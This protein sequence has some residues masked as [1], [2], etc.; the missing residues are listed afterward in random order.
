MKHLFLARLARPR[1]SL[2]CVILYSLLL[3]MTMPAAPL[4]AAVRQPV[5]MS[6]DAVAAPAADSSAPSIVL[7][8]VIRDATAVAGVAE[9][10]PSNTLLAAIDGASQTT[11]ELID[12]TG[13][14]RRLS[15]LT[16]MDDAVIASTAAG[17]VFI[18][19]GS[20]IARVAPDGTLTSSFASVTG[21]I[22]ALHTSATHHLIA[23]T[24]GGGVWRVSTTG[25][26]THVADCGKA[27]SAVITVPDDEGRY[28]AWAGAILVAAR[29]EARLFAIDAAGVVEPF[30]IG[31]VARDLAL[32][33]PNRN[34]FG[35]D[36]A[37]A[38]IRGARAEAFA[39]MEGDIVVAQHAPGILARV[40]WNGTTFE[41]IQIGKAERWDRITFA[42]AGV[43]AIPPAR[44]IYDAIAVV[45]HAPMLDS[46]RIEGALWQ[47]TA[48]NVTLDGTDVITSDLLMPGT[49]SVVLGSGK[50][51][52]AGVITGSDGSEPKTHTLSISGSAS[53]RH[54][55]N[56]TDPIELTSIVPPPAPTGTRD[57]ALT[58]AGSVG[59][60][61]T[62]RDLSI[63]GKAGEVVIPPGTYGRFEATGRT[64]FILGSSGTRSTYNLTRLDLAGG[65]ELRVLG[66][67]VV[68]LRDGVTVTGSSAGTAEAPARLVLNVA[69]GDVS[70][71]GT[72]VVNALVRAPGSR[73]TIDGNGLLRGSI[74]ADRLSVTGNGVLQVTQTDVP[75][76]ATNR[77]P[78]VDAGADQ[79]LTL[80]ADTLRLEGSVS[81]DALPRNAQ[82]TI[83][84][85]R[86]SGPDAVAFSD[87][88]TAATSARFTVPGT[89]VLRLTVDDGA[90]RTSDDVTITVIPEN[91]PPAAEAG[92][93]QRIELPAKA[94]LSGTATD[95][96]LPAGSSLVTT[97][98]RVAGPGTV[99]FDDAT[100]LATRAAFTAAG[101]H[102][103][104]L[105]ATDGEDTVSDDLTIT[106]DSEN[107]APLVAAGDDQ[108]IVLPNGTTLRGTASDDGWPYGSTFTTNWTTLS[109][110][111]KVT[112]GDTTN[113]ETTATFTAAGV[114][115]LRLSATD[116]R[117]T[118][119]DDVT[120]TVDPIN[121][122]PLV[123]A[124]ADSVVELPEPAALRGSVT[125]DG[126]P[127]GSTLTQQ[128]SVV[129]GT[130]VTFADATA[131]STTATFVSA[132]TYTLRLTAT[133]GALS[134]SD[135]VTLTVHPENQPPAVDAG[136][137][138]TIRLPATAALSGEASDDGWPFGS[139][140]TTAWSKASGPGSVTFADAAALA[141][142][143]SF[144]T[145]GTYVLRLSATD[146]RVT[147]IDELTVVVLPAN[148]P[149]VVHAGAD[150]AASTGANLVRNGGGEAVR[151]DG[152]I[153]GWSVT[154]GN[155]TR[156]E[157][158]AAEGDAYLVATAAGELTQ[159]IA[160]AGLPEG[161]NFELS[162]SLRGAAR[163]AF[164]FRGGDGSILG[165]FEAN[166]AS[167]A[168][169]TSVSETRAGP[170]GTATVAVRLM[171]TGE[172][173]FDAI[174]VRAPG[175]ATIDLLGTITDDGLP[176][177]STLAVS[178]SAVSGPAAIVFGDP[179]RAKT[180]AAFSQPGTYVLRLDA[181]DGEMSAGDEM[182]VVVG[183]ANQPPA[184]DA[185]AAQSVRL[186]ATV[187]LAGRA[188]DDGLP[189]GSALSISWTALTGA[190]SVSIAGPGTLTPTLTFAT[191]G[192]FILRLTVTDSEFTI[193]DDVTITVAAANQPPVVSA[194]ADVTITLP[195]PATLAG[196]AS[197]EDGTPVA[198]Q[199]TV[200]SGGQVT[201]ADP[202]SATTTA[203]F[204]AAGTYI[205]R[206]TGN[207][208]ELSASDDV[209]ITVEAER[210]NQAPVVDAGADLAIDLG[211]AVGLRGSATDDG[212]PRASVLT[213]TWAKISGPGSVVFTDAAAAVTEASFDAP[214]I[215]VLRL[216][217]SDSALSS[218]DDVSVT[219]TPAL[220]ARFSVAGTARN[221]APLRSNIAS[222]HSGA[223]VVAA[224]ASSPASAVPE[225]ALDDDPGSYWRVS[226]G[227]TAPFLIVRLP[228]ATPA[229]FDRIR[230]VT[231]G[232]SE[233][234]LNFRVQV[235]STT[236]DD[237]AFTTILT[238]TATA[239][240]RVQE[241][242]LATPAQG[243]YVRLV[244]LS[245]RTGFAQVRSFDAVQAEG[246]GVP[247]Y[248]T[249]PSISKA[250]D[251]AST[252]DATTG[253][254]QAVIDG[255][256]NT[257]WATPRT[258]AQS[259]TI[260]LPQTYLADRIRIVNSR[261]AVAMKNF[262]VEV[263]SG[264][265][266]TFTEV[267][268]GVARNDTDAPQEFVFSSPRQTRL[269]RFT[270]LDNY[271]S[272]T[273]MSVREIDVV[274]VQ[275]HHISSSSYSE[276]GVGPERVLDDTPTT[277][278]TSAA[279]R[280]AGEFIVVRVNPS[281][282]APVA[283]VTLQST[284]AH[285]DTSAVREFDVFVSTTT[286]D[287]AA[288]TKVL[289]GTAPQLPQAQFFRFSGGPIHARF[290]KLVVRSNYGGDSVRVAT[291]WPMTVE[292][293][294]SAVSMTTPVAPTRNL[295]PA[296]T[297][298]GGKIVAASSGSAAGMLDYFHGS[299]WYTAGTTNQWV[300]IE[301]AGS[302]THTLTGVTIAPELAYT[303]IPNAFVRD[304]EIWVSAT[305]AEESAFSKVFAGAATLNDVNRFSF[306]PVMARYVKYVPL[307]AQSATATSI[308]TGYFDVVIE[309]HPGGVAGYSSRFTANVGELAFDGSTGTSWYTATGAVTDQWITVA[310]PAGEVRPVH[311][312]RIVAPSSVAP[313]QFEIRVST[314]TTDPAAFT[315]VLSGTYHT[316]F[317]HYYFSAPHAAKY[318][319]FFW[320]NG[321][322]TSNIAV[323]ELGVLTVPSDGAA[324]IGY[325][326]A[327]NA[328]WT[329]AGT[330][331]I[332]PLNNGWTTP[333]GR[334]ANEHFTVALRGERTWV[335]DHVSMQGALLNHSSYSP[336]DFEVQVSDG[337]GSNE[338]FRTVLM[339]TLRREVA[340]QEQHFFFEP[341]RARYVRV[342][343]RNNWGAP[344]IIMQAF[345]VYSSE[346]GATRAQF[347]DTSTGAP[348][349]WQW[350]FGDGAT[351]SERSPLHVYA[352]PGVY[353]VHLTVTDASSRTSTHTS[354]Y[355][356]T[357]GPR[358]DFTIAPNPGNEGSG[359]NVVD[360][361]T[362]NVGQLQAHHWIWGDGKPDD[363]VNASSSHTYTDN[364]VY[365]ITH[366][367]RNAYGISAT[368]QKDVTI[369]NVP[370]TA[371][372]GPDL[373]VQ[374]G[375]DWGVR[376]F[377][378]DAGEADR[379]SLRCVWTFGDGE[380]HEQ[381][382]CYQ[383][384]APHAY[385]DPGVYAATLTVF[386][387]DGAS[388]T[389]SVKV[390]VGLRDT[391]AF[392]SGQREVAPNE[393]MN[394]EAKLRDAGRFTPIVG[395]TLQFDVGGQIV[396]ATTDAQGI[397]TAP[398]VYTGPS[399][400]P[401]VTV[402][403][404][405][406][407]RYLA[408]SYAFFANCAG[409]PRPLDIALVFDVSGSLSKP[410]PFAQ[411]AARDF[412]KS[413]APAHQV[414]VVSFAD[415]GRLDQPLTTDRALAYTAIDNLAIRGGTQIYHGIR[416][417]HDELVGLRHKPDAAPVM[418]LLSDGEDFAGQNT[419]DAANRAKAAGIRIV[420]V[421]F[422]E[423]STGK[424]LMKS[425]ASSVADYWIAESSEA[426]EGI[427]A[428]IVDTLCTPANRPPVVV[429]G[430]DQTLVLPQNSVALD[431]T[432]TDDG[433]PEGQTVTTA[434][435]KSSGPGTVAFADANAVDTT[436]TFSA[437]GVYVLTLTANDTEFTRVDQV[438]ITVAENDAPV[439]NAGDDR[440][441][442]LPPGTVGLDGTVTDDGL[443]TAALS[444]AWTVSSGPGSV[445]FADPHA[446][447]TTA[448][449]TTPGTYVL[450]LTA[451][452]SLLESTDQIVLTVAENAPPTV[453]A[454]IDRSAT[455]EANLLVNGGNDES[456]VDGAIRGW[457]AVSGTWL[458]PQPGMNGLPDAVRGESYFFAGGDATAEL[459]QD[460]DVSAFAARI[461]AGQQEFAW[462]AFART[463]AEA[464]P[465][466]ADVIVE[467]R[468]ASRTAVLLGRGVEITGAEWTKASEI[469]QAPAGTRWI[470]VRVKS[471]RRSG[472]ATDVFVD[473]VT[474][475]AIG[476]AHAALAGNASDDGIPEPLQAAWTVVS[477]PGSVTFSDASSPDASAVADAAGEYMLR[478]TATDGVTSVSDDV[479]LTVARANAAP[480]VAAG[481]DAEIRL[482]SSATLS[483]TSS[484]DGHPAP[485]SIRWQLLSGPEPV[486]FSDANAA[487]THVT[488]ATGGT[489]RFRV[490]ADD[491]DEIAFDTVTINVLSEAGNAAPVVDAGADVLISPPNTSATLAAT[492]TDDG[493]PSGS[494]LGLTWSQFSGPGTTTFSD[495][496]SRAPTVTFDR[497]GIYVLRLTATD[498]ELTAT[499]DM[500][501]SYDGTNT[502][503][504]VDAG[505]DQTVRLNVGA[506]L[507]ATVADD[508]LPLGSTLSLAWSKVSGPGTVSFASNTSA[509]TNATFSETGS[510]VLRLTASD[511]ALSATDEMTITVEPALPPPTVDITSPVSGATITD[512]TVFSGVVSEGATWR[513]E[514][515]LNG[516]DA[517]AGKNA[518]T[519]LA[520]GVGP[521]NGPL[522]TFD[523]TVLLNGT[524][525]VRLVAVGDDGQTETVS[526]TA[527][528][529]GDLKLGLFTLSFTDLKVPVGP[530]PIELVRT[531]DSRDKRVGDFGTGWTLEL[532]SI[533]LDKSGVLGT[534]WE[535]TTSGFFATKTYCLVAAVPRYVTVTFPNGKVFRFRATPS[536]ECQGLVPIDTTTIR[537]VPV[538]HTR[539]TLVALGDNDVIVSGSKPGPVELLNPEL[540]NPS[541]FRLTLNDGTSYVIDEVL[542]V[543]SVTDVN[544]N[545]ITVGE[546]GV[547]HS[548]G[549][550]VAFTRDAAG[551]ITRITDPAGRTISY[552]YDGA[553]D[554]VQVTNRA[555]EETTYTYAANHYL[556]SIKDT[557]GI[558]P[559]RNEFDAAGRLIRTTDAQGKVTVFSIDVA[560][561]TEVITDRAGASTTLRYDARGNVLASTD[562]LGNR[563]TFTYD[564]AGNKISMTNAVGKTVTYAYDTR[565]NLIATTDPLGNMNRYEHDD[566][567]RV[568][569]HVDANGGVTTHK[570]DERGRPI[571]TTDTLG[572]VTK[573]SYTT[574]G[575]VESITHPNGSVT[576]FQHN[577]LG[578][579][580]QETGPDGR[581]T[582]FEFDANG[583][584]TTIIDVPA[585]TAAASSPVRTNTDTASSGV[586]VGK[587]IYDEEDRLRRVDYA[588][589]G[590]RETEYDHRRLP[591]RETDPIGRSVTFEYDSMGRRIRTNYPDGSSDSKTY[592]AEGRVIAATD[593]GGLTTQYTW[594]AVG[595]LVQATLPDGS[596]ISA[597]YDGL[598][599]V[600]SR[601]L[602]T[603]ART[604]YEYDPNCG[605]TERLT[606]VT[607]ALGQSA[608][609]TYDS[610]NRRTS[611]TDAQGRTTTFEY[612]AGN[613]VS[614]ITYADGTAK[615]AHYNATGRLTMQTD[616]EGKVT[617]FEYDAADRPTRVID[618]LGQVTQYIYDSRG[619]LAESIDAAGRKS[620]F[621]YDI[622]DRRTGRTLPL[623]MTQT[624]TYD[625]AGQIL[626]RTDFNGKTTHY[627]Y[628]AMGRTLSETPDA[629]LSDSAVT[630]QY[631]AMG[632]RV[633]MQDPSGTT[634]YTYDE[635]HRLVSVA[636]PAG[637]LT[638]TYNSLNK[639]T[640]VRSS[641]TDG[642]AV[643]YAYDIIGRLE[644][645]TDHRTGTAMATYDY[646]GAGNVA[647]LAYGN[648]LRTEYA[649]DVL[650]RL[651][652]VKTWA[653]APVAA[654]EYTL[655][656]TGR[657]VGVTELGG[658]SVTYSYDALYR[659]IRERVTGDPLGADGQVDYT[660]DAVGNRLTRTSTLMGVADAAYAYD[661]ND[662]PVADTFD[663][664][665]NP[666]AA[667]GTEF[668]YDFA[669]RLTNVGDSITIV[670]NGDGDRASKTVGG[671]T[672]HY[673]VDRNNP[674]GLAQV[675]E[676]IQAGVVQRVYT[677]GHQLIHQRQ[678]AGG[679]WMSRYY[680]H[681]GHGSTRY[682]ADD[683]G[684]VTDTYTYDAFGVLIARTGSTPNN[685]L[686]AGEQFDPDLGMYYLRARY[687]EPGS[688]R[689]WTMDAYEGN[690][691]DP[692]SL[693]K[694]TYVH[695]D[696]VNNV[697]P[698]GFALMGEMVA[699]MRTSSIL[700]TIGTFAMR[701]VV[702]WFRRALIGAIAGAG[703][704]ATDSA[705]GALEEGRIL[706]EAWEGGKKGLVIGAITGPLVAIRYIKEALA[707]AGVVVSVMGA[708]DSARH[709]KYAQATFRAMTALIP[710]PY[711][712][713]KIRQLV[714][715]VRISQGGPGGAAVTGE[716]QWGARTYSTDVNAHQSL[717]IQQ[718]G[719]DG[720]KW[721]ESLSPA[722][723]SHSGNALAA[724][725][726]IAGGGTLWRGGK[727]DRSN[728]GK[729]AQYWAAEYPLNPDYGARYGLPPENT[730]FDFTEMA[731]IGNG[732]FITRVSPP[733]GTNP[734]GGIEIVVPPGGTTTTGFSGW[735]N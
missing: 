711:V 306:A 100:Q 721:Y 490:S 477:G 682:L 692:P 155:F 372:A 121:E 529:E 609:F 410:L 67:V 34:F 423:S 45:R 625:K 601:T 187:T 14:R 381:A 133:D 713:Q 733:V 446:V 173:S 92:A 163:V 213:M 149:P 523:P 271:G 605:C 645:V 185:G 725:G 572:N 586:P 270:M 735:G 320:Q 177:G 371:N 466:A 295:S 60:F 57:V 131:A 279:Q 377:T 347:V 378:H 453:S 686:Y 144:A 193:H 401:K 123:S 457:T 633:A 129:A 526:V 611:A 164:E 126:W 505:V 370:P 489:Y 567:G 153:E 574:A 389:D 668:S 50:P 179:S 203:G 156:A 354:K 291:F 498:G 223:S 456:L 447:D 148:Q 208:G 399:D 77:P 382:D 577:Q 405:G 260:V 290:V 232:S 485:L 30:S 114:Y 339:G 598:G 521:V 243:R 346:A 542:G 274:P 297:A 475:R 280:T 31:V 435:S 589:G 22:A 17:D 584:Q 483:A 434:W 188:S 635:L 160:V 135:E 228:G 428:S 583:N 368:A 159:N 335:V 134:V 479:A 289:S 111:G 417:A 195:D 32:V 340:A 287:P 623:G 194:G 718:K 234:V 308:M 672:T 56:R 54:L 316:N 209:T 20:I 443:P 541:Q 154:S 309:P 678:L 552:R 230:L 636:S 504:T 113:P 499:D 85:T 115:V 29:D 337:D 449:F 667:R 436:A 106:V 669:D 519:V 13:S 103:L 301:L 373:T 518:W 704:G 256:T 553:G 568:L 706:D 665:G 48:E 356:A 535:E 251:R 343:V 137:D 136:A 650:D 394:L 21:E 96:G 331:D 221:A 42:A 324:L 334:T 6:D 415:E 614:R 161:S 493:L 684:V 286:D 35:V 444:T 691:F 566:A 247:N 397:A 484:D 440:G 168:G 174:S 26:A 439:V 464:I 689:F 459:Q 685:Y 690:G 182:S 293:E 639:V 196:S 39:A 679:T 654:Y 465:D 267:L 321:T 406:D 696:P 392:Y 204:A 365:T 175:L 695:G 24:S 165:S 353:D 728:T 322:S 341:V 375:D 66:D 540:Y 700:S 65:S 146:T 709:G 84:W 413:L 511:T 231:P 258:P 303:T 455:I 88:S 478:L 214:G 545:T 653:A 273:T 524:Y 421:V 72:A 592:D 104:R 442:A 141:T 590:F 10:V 496:T 701:G 431:A 349:A 729:D 606:K 652:S 651:Q 565:N 257:A 726:P 597:T 638:Y 226:V 27:A 666:L 699:V 184:V 51:S 162:A 127:R 263:T 41:T 186:P 561:R 143:A 8:E 142:T 501:V 124:D 557:K 618:A 197:D 118:R 330:L 515:R 628:D 219:V 694:Y 201:F 500:T 255:F 360:R 604:T 671:V 73:V 403:F 411:S 120:I 513:L 418:I 336:R 245:A 262:R 547:V 491:S 543:R 407:A 582:Q 158:G 74:G 374:W 621:A 673:L 388:A 710:I 451:S 252:S 109:G 363:R 588:D 580:T 63:S 329:P 681:D 229:T 385:A 390:T 345:R 152:T 424:L 87:A 210:V 319:Q 225:Q 58:S 59:D 687:M 414:A 36:R 217:A 626:S 404:A 525:K 358:V 147:T 697:D 90:L 366:T 722:F 64:A 516:N 71:S 46:G 680:G 227:T 23:V 720:M 509:I 240:D 430:T 259:L 546:T 715:T 482:P 502:A 698:T 427:Y 613:R 563:T 292:N 463:A 717:A 278:W 530:L 283:G 660:H 627:S 528:V 544:G 730:N 624:V 402:S 536:V 52:F 657:R 727:L 445:T 532:K 191:A 101:V 615:S 395:A 317:T 426:L 116:G 132:G 172:A 409:N 310:L 408:S 332:E 637:T 9:H 487:S 556:T 139:T 512:R 670:Y 304:F 548:S 276:A 81:D 325:S 649:Y 644:Q 608:A 205:L 386:D 432:V 181:T 150:A 503:P 575:A 170:A 538:G 294:G 703:L 558:Q 241:F 634:R 151:A 510:Y 461:D 307:S 470:R 602:P 249:P 55:V 564:G 560:G 616:Q 199:W 215:Y 11:L 495:A 43:G 69:S 157:G 130:G 579:V 732:P 433:L 412:V 595:R 593:R 338:S 102:T 619:N 514:Y 458:R 235:S 642:L 4:F 224:T 550:S 494:T 145:A 610:L 125:D 61:A 369:L 517:A 350:Q 272:S 313:K 480:S 719:W 450:T 216:T 539:G 622:M 183:T 83:E 246:S 28:G 167:S 47:L 265:A 702:M 497:H 49:P 312:V 562:A 242:I 472:T 315:T 573:M 467:Y 277:F 15:T 631:N 675:V 314:T 600:T 462:F 53:L 708:A 549:K 677:W 359:I 171:A 38:V 190:E 723:Q 655:D 94:I 119:S 70:V 724:R 688:G 664:N 25:V 326:S 327:L 632:Q 178:W 629:S 285:N 75:P 18:A 578:Q 364:G 212:L 676:E 202:T 376:S 603:G 452:D 348:I 233:S 342:I 138:A 79:T 648:G 95:D 576:T 105:T 355:D 239:V 640:T 416:V 288:F 97:W 1:Q 734:G 425:L 661:E 646:D 471:T 62:L 300:K 211:D 333:V 40:R 620:T 476:A 82:L 379:K 663:A 383:R 357:G 122:A 128:W 93:D 659:L 393:V 643:D 198:V 460:V 527:S 581:V 268:T 617:R 244:I 7:T 78:S 438:T 2:V 391:F 264:D 599:R 298:N 551:R 261:D 396:T 99:T 712:Y 420:T 68:N 80:P 486:T 305:T 662:R 362:S 218:S 367:V 508:N 110:P 473:A 448:T 492:V 318:V 3:Q 731:T 400:A 571:E 585:Q 180:T 91:K 555:A 206:L 474:L 591:I 166:P 569:R 437:E 429:A 220:A 238:A 351:S 612:D 254:A 554:L 587:L 441:V 596:S 714:G 250:A 531:Y 683:D 269:V 282:P 488:F 705:L 33:Q 454:G 534:G 344:Q 328:A 89:Y 108:F 302:T 380:T 507:A 533:R 16:G 422:G 693:H 522:G 253:G 607:N 98:S 86:V 468:D 296:Q 537:F 716:V 384:L 107:Q 520:S 236:P 658:R 323:S 299:P 707:V 398:L 237:S 311:G 352:D 117:E 506:S 12:T 200:V 469:N 248:H 284:P 275:T 112:F 419:V 37:T 481:P 266:T 594:D 281:D 674:T 189:S 5:P 361:S 387:K 647:E 559:I 44:R 140:L 630:Y 76:P 192:T 19:A 222:I 176:A 641:N 169:W 656:R 570:Y 207:D